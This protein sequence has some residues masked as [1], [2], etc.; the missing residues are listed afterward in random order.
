MNKTELTEIVDRLTKKTSWD[1]IVDCVEKIATSS[2]N[3]TINLVEEIGLKKSVIEKSGI[4]N[5]EYNTISQETKCRITDEESKEKE[6][7]DRIT[8]DENI[9]KQEKIRERAEYIL[10]SE[11][12]M[13]FLERIAHKFHVGD[14]LIIRSL[15]CSVACQSVPNSKGIQLK[16]SG[17]SGKGK[18]AVCKTVGHIV[19]KTYFR[20][21]S[22]TPKVLYYDDT[23]ETGTT[24]LSDDTSLSDDMEE[25]VKRSSSNYQT[26]TEHLTIVRGTVKKFTIPARLNWWFTNV[27]D[28]QSMQVLNRQ[29]QLDVDTS[30]E[31]DAEVFKSRRERD[32][33]L[34]FFVDED[35][36]VCR[37]IFSILREDDNQLFVKIP[38]INKIHFPDIHNRRNPSI[39]FDF[40][41]AFTIINFKNRKRNKDNKLLADED[42]F[43]E[44]SKIYN[45]RAKQQRY[46]LNDN[47]INILKVLSDNARPIVTSEDGWFEIAA[48][49]LQNVL[50]VEQS[51]LTNRMNGRPDRPESGLLSKCKWI[52]KDSR[53]EAVKDSPKK[54]MH[55]VTYY[56]ITT[57]DY[58]KE[59]DKMSDVDSDKVRLLDEDFNP[60]I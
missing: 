39:F 13:K 26:I 19:P 59:I 8:H 23:L 22:V 35:V 38:Y 45:P 29:F 31:Q 6:R 55:N 36:L 15:I 5:N 57:I 21:T 2:C 53:N 28:D 12:P 50:G 16:M 9:K 41:R 43:N 51:T 4:K 58:R 11:N 34:E 37:E 54:G 33:E 17:T 14:D 20:E 32:D 1:D 24:I 7:T 44:A 18:S 10:K 46:K 48:K 42:D 27:D 47:E 25:T 52:R 56:I 30:S 3:K 60:T 49:D 40:I